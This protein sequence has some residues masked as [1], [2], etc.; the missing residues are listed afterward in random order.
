ML[1]YFCLLNHHK[2]LSLKRKADYQ[3]GIIIAVVVTLSLIMI[4]RVILVAFS[5]DIFI[6]MSGSIIPILVIID[7]SIRFFIKKNASSNIFPYLTLPIPRKVLLWN[8]VLSDWQSFWMLGCWGIYSIIIYFC[9]IFNVRNLITVLLFVV[10]NNYL[11]AFVKALTGGYSPLLFPVCVFLV[12]IMLFISIFLNFA[13]VMGMLI[14]ISF[15][16]LLAFFV[17]TRKSGVIR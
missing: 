16:F 4:L 9:G 6:E 7:F 12:C 14:I 8:L 17:K 5:K 3:R 11:A 10:L 15:S 13:W 1:K 2:S